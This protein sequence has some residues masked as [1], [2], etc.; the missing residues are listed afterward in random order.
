[1]KRL[2]VVLAPLAAVA[3]SACDGS[4]DPLTSTASG[5]VTVYDSLPATVPPGMPSHSFQAQQTSEFG[6]YVKLAPSTGRNLTKVTV[7]MV[8]Y[9]ETPAY[10]HPITLNLYNPG[11]LRHPFAFETRTFAIPA[12]HP[13]DPSCGDATPDSP[14]RKWKAAD[15]VC[16]N[17][18]AFTLT[19]DLTGVVVPDEFV[20][21]IAYDTSGYGAHPTGVDGNY[22]NLNVGMVT[23]APS[24]GAWVANTVYVNMDSG[25]QDFAPAARG[26]FGPATP[27][28]STNNVDY[29]P[30]VKFEVSP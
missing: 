18:E 24:V 12:R 27:G 11:D 9:G 17:G 22:D 5:P 6:D 30:A 3:L 21:G 8:T 19:F 29:H 10:S 14:W 2:G 4:T 13:W 20:F 28:P 26:V 1:M 16:R 23:A 15:G 7:A 25:P